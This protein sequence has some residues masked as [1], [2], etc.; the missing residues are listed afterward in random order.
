MQDMMN[1]T[2]NVITRQLGTAVVLQRKSDEYV[3]ATQL[4]QAARKEWS[5]Y[6]KNKGVKDFITALVVSPFSTSLIIVDQKETGKSEEDLIQTITT[7]PNDNRGTWV[8]KLLAVDLARWCSPAFALQVMKWTVAVLE[9][10]LAGVVPDALKNHD[11]L[12]NTES[13]AIIISRKRKEREEDLGVEEKELQLHR[14][15]QELEFQKQEHLLRLEEQRNRLEEQ[16]NRVEADKQNH[17]T[18][19]YSEP[20]FLGD[21]IIQQ[22]IKDQLAQS[23][24]SGNKLPH[25]EKF[26]PDMT[27]IANSL[28]YSTLG[29]SQRT[30]LGQLLAREFKATFQGEKMLKTRRFVMGEMRDVNAYTMN[31]KEWLTGLISQW[32]EQHRVKRKRTMTL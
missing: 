23:I 10:D 16:R 14:E 8:C 12:N 19:L 15:K 9:G 1:N 4:C 6:Y 27:E 32:C 5:N 18:K 13:Q 21:A 17:L 25:E 2:S 7:G 20:A 26:A 28:G 31:K 24:T 11:V 30:K 29:H 22:V 3:N